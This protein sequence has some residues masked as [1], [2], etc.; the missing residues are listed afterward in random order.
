L[1]RSRRACSAGR[2]AVSPA[3]DR[4]FKLSVLAKGLDGALETIGGVL[5][6]FVS[7]QS[8]ERTIRGLL[9]HE[10]SRDPHDFIA[11]HLLRS[12]QE[13]SHGTRIF[14]AVYLLSH[15][16][17][18]VVVVV[19]VLRN[20]T[21]AYPAMIALLAA[22]VVYQLYKL[23]LRVTLGMTLLTVFDLFVIWLTWREYQARRGDHAPAPA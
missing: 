17:A 9:A 20:K 23:W 10:L 6:F 14:A 2:M 22:F 3:L 13:V 18:K 4:T 19:A 5:L 11:R 16:L 1:H 21:W 7:P 12:V 8:M 15:G